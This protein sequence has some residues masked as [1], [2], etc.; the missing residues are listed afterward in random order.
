MEVSKKNQI[1]IE[2]SESELNFKN[3]SIQINLL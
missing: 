2:G 1:E 3:M